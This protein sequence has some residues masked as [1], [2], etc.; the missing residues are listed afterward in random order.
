MRRALRGGVW[1]CLFSCGS[2]SIP[3]EDVGADRQTPL[4][5]QSRAL[6]QPKQDSQSPSSGCDEPSTGGDQSLKAAAAV[7][8]DFK[9][10][11]LN[12]AAQVLTSAIERTSV[13]MR[14]VHKTLAPGG[15]AGVDF[16]LV[17]LTLKSGDCL[18]SL[19]A[20]MTLQEADPA[21]VKVSLLTDRTAHAI[22]KTFVGWRRSTNSNASQDPTPAL[23][24]AIAQTVG[25]L[26]LYKTAGQR[27]PSTVSGIAIVDETTREAIWIF[28]RVVEPMV[29]H[30][31]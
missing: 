17:R 7:T 15:I 16:I 5:A 18:A 6:D 28:A 8:S 9:S 11:R 21:A 3:A 31:R 25:S 24:A 10:S 14:G 26:R 22:D 23:A 29:E 19:S 20:A 1:L 2:P 12:S 27:G 13:A 30:H 4:A